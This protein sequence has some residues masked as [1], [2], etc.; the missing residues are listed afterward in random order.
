VAEAHAEDAAQV[1]A[2]TGPIRVLDPELHP[3]QLGL[4]SPERVQEVAFT[5]LPEPGL[6]GEVADAEL[7]LHAVGTRVAET[8]S[9]GKTAA[10]GRSGRCLAADRA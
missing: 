8:T 5:E 3:A 2:A 6:D 9:R 10:S 4:E 7:E 1:A